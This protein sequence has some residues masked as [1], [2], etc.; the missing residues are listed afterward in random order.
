MWRFEPKLPCT[1]HAH[2][3][4]GR[5]CHPLEQSRAEHAAPST[6][7]ALTAPSQSCPVQGPYPF[8]AHLRSTS[9]VRTLLR[10]TEEENRSSVEYCSTDDCGNGASSLSGRPLPGELH[11]S[12]F[13]P[14]GEARLDSTRDATTMTWTP[15]RWAT[16]QIDPLGLYTRREDGLA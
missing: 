8:S 6:P 14:E 12:F 10:N 11:K 15:L 7:I 1:L 5:A 16:T 13:R 3:H 9:M 4:S 2:G